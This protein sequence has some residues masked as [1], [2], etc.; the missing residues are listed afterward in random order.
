MTRLPHTGNE[1]VLDAISLIGGLSA[2]SSRHIWVARPAPTE[3][4]HDQILP[5]DWNSIAKCGSTGTNYQVMPGDRIY[6]NSDYWKSFDSRVA[7]VLSPFERML[8]FTLLGSS[9]VNSI[10]NGSN[11]GGG[12]GTGIGR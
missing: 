6:V 2:V 3:C 9:T 1:T 5:V 8:G 12:S 10:K 4:G 7:K 11:G